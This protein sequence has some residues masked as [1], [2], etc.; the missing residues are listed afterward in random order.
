[1][2]QGSATYASEVAQAMSCVHD[3]VLEIHD[4]NLSQEVVERNG[5]WLQRHRRHYRRLFLSH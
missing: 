2:S 5:L 4:T 1:M 3:G